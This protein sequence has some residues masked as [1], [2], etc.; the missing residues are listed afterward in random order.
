MADTQKV[1]AKPTDSPWAALSLVWELGFLIALPAF[2][3]GFG[4]AYL[5]KVLSTSPLCLIAGL[6]FALTISLV[7]VYR[8]V[9]RVL[10]TL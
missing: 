7:T 4:G 10:S 2:A 8:S 6:G 3:L 1:S 9:K 5:D